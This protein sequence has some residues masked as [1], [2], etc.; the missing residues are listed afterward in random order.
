M[1]HLGNF[2]NK[3]MKKSNKNLK[4]DTINR[5]RIRMLKLRS[6]VKRML[7]INACHFGKKRGEEKC[8]KMKCYL[9]IGPLRKY[10][11]K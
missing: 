2:R 8:K 6:K 3:K 7:K 4:K 9:S 10:I 5:W 1:K 11:L